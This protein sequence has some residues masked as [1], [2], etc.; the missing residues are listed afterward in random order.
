MNCST[1]AKNRFKSS[2]NLFFTLIRNRYSAGNYCTAYACGGVYDSVC[3]KLVA[4]SYYPDFLSR[5][6]LCQCCI[7]PSKSQDEIDALFN[8][9]IVE[10]VWKKEAISNWDNTSLR[11]THTSCVTHKMNS[12]VLH[13]SSQTIEIF[14]FHFIFKFVFYSERDIVKPYTKQVIHLLGSSYHL[15][16]VLSNLIQVAN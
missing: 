1:T 2:N 8:R 3:A 10:L 5:N 4:E 14:I 7:R 6:V 13:W 15:P 11:W 12:S 16:F 9:N